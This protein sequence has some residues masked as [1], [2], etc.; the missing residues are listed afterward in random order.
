MRCRVEC[1]R[2]LRCH[3]FRSYQQEFWVFQRH[4]KQL[5]WLSYT[6][7]FFVYIYIYK[8]PFGSS[9]RA[10][11]S[12]STSCFVVCCCICITCGLSL[13]FVCRVTSSFGFVDCPPPPPPR[14]PPCYAVL[15]VHILISYKCAHVPMILSRCPYGTITH[16]A[17]RRRH[18]APL[19]R[20]DTEPLRPRRLVGQLD[21]CTEHV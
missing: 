13:A 15:Y 18:M 16:D 3:G 1:E 2:K 10:F 6:G 9:P 19:P 12:I 20:A 17:G 4:R 11:F 8:P 5:G 21:R 14:R 7:A